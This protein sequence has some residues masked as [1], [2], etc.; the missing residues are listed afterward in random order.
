MDDLEKRLRKEL[1]RHRVT[2]GDVIPFPVKKK[3]DLVQ[4]IQHFADELPRAFEAQAKAERSVIQSI[5]KLRLEGESAKKKFYVPFIMNDYVLGT[6][7]IQALVWVL[8]EYLEYGETERKH[9]KVQI[10]YAYEFL[11][12]NLSTMLYAI[13]KDLGIA[14]GLLSKTLNLS[15]PIPNYAARPIDSYLVE[16]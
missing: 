5:N 8:E 15:I 13:E 14:E 2:E 11:D 4:K 16:L 3:E 10:K 6:N 7:P 9:S 12:N 1:R